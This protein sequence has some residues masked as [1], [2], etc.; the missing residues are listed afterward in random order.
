MSKNH[1]SDDLVPAFGRLELF[2][3]PVFESLGIRAI[4]LAGRVVKD[5]APPVAGLLARPSIGSDQL[6]DKLHPFVA[7]V[8]GFK[9]FDLR[10]C[11][12]FSRQVERNPAEKRHVVDRVGNRCTR[13]S[14]D[15]PIEI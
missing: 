2:E 12:Y 7:G 1:F 5:N 14:L 3:Q 13:S 4:A 8:V 10:G 15:H 6:V 11:R 9:L